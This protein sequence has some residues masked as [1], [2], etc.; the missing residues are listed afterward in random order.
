MR[1]H[2]FITAISLCFSIFAEAQ[3]PQLTVDGKTNNGVLLEALKIEI[4]VCGTVAR[5]TWQMTFKNTTAIILEGTLNFPLKDGLSVSRYAIDI[6]GKMREAVPVDRSKGT[7]VFEAIERRRVDP[8]LLEKVDGNTFRTRIYPINPN[9]KRTVL[10]GYEEELPIAAN[11]AL[12]YNLP[13]HL[14]D[15]VKDFNLDVSVIQ[16]A[17]RPVFD[18]SLNENIEFSASNNLYVAAVHKNNYVPAYSLSFSIPKPLDAA[19][20]MMQ[21][22]ENKYYYLI[23]TRLQ[24][25]E[26][27]KKL[28]SAIGLL[29]DAS[30]SGGNRNI[31]KELELLDG[32]FKKLNTVEVN[33]VVFSNTVKSNSHF[34][35]QNGTWN[36]L[37]NFIEKI[38]YDGATNLGNINLKNIPGDEY[39]LVS[40]G[41]Q[42]L[43]YKQIQLSNKPVYCINSAAAADYSNLKFIALKTGGRVIDLQ[44]ST[45]ADALQKL[46][47]EP[48]RFLGIK[49]N[50][51]VK[52]NYP[53][54]PVAV[55]TDFSAAGITEEG[56]QEIVFQYGY[57]NKVTYEKIFSINT[58]TQLCENFDITKMFAQKKI[59]ELDIQYNQNKQEIERLGKQFGVITRNTS[60]I[61]L[62]TVN[63]YVHYG[64]EPPSELK[65]EYNRIMK[66]RRG[67]IITKNKDDLEKTL[68]MIVNL[69]KWYDQKPVKKEITKPEPVVTIVPA[70]SANIPMPA[71]QPVPAPTRPAGTQTTIP[72]G[73]SKVISGT[74]VDIDGNPVSFASVKIKGTSTG[75]S[76]DANG[77][78]S[79][80]VNSNASIIISGASFKEV[81]VPVGNQNIINSV[82][83]K[84]G[85]ELKEVV[86]TS[87]FGIRRSARSTASNVQYLNGDQI[88]TISQSNVNN[89]LAGKVTGVQI[90]SQP[91]VRFGAETT[92]RLRGE[93][94][95]GTGAGALYVVDGNIMPRRADINPDDVKDYSVLQGP[96]AAALFG[97]D[98]ANGAVIITTKN[99]KPDSA[100]KK[101]EDKVAEANITTKPAKPLFDL[102]TFDYIKEIKNTEK[103]AHYLKYLELRQFYSSRPVYFFNVATYLLKTG[104]KV[105]GLTVLSNLA[106]L[107]NGSYELYKMLGYKLKEAGDYEGELS[108]F[109]KV[110]E[111][112]PAD[113]QSY[114]DCALAYADQGNYQLALDLLY[115]GM[116]KSYSDEMDEMYEGIEEIFL[117]EINHIITLHKSK[118]NIKNIDKRIITPL[119]TD[120]RIVMNWN[121]NNTDIDLWVTDPNGEK[122]FFSKPETSIGGR[123]SED[124]TEG[125]GPEQFIIKKGIKGKYKV[126]IDYYGDTQI[127]LAGATT[128]MAEIYLHYG[129]DKEEKRII[130]L[131]MKKE[132]TGAVFIGEVEL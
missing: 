30:L 97:P 5:T 118:L 27:E 29:W 58:E 2:F 53:S 57:G 33:L 86:V 1:K 82:L 10:I 124:F 107:E 104:D 96:A 7:E 3:M 9:S 26:R 24:N 6:N 66:Q 25:N 130:T 20:V 67:D 21:Q 79:V 76:C 71:P 75:V 102:D 100:Y 85:G 131:Q 119:Q 93:N 16:S 36:E 42:T 74:V 78:Y 14:K 105:N 116:T 19:E 40:D 95:L 72:P 60:L 123:L 18:S 41:R 39:V 106:E 109:K 4:K 43:G 12:H 11:S 115:A 128:I 51:F 28:P 54:I 122:C 127:T 32:Y 91:G 34:R 45:V 52:E 111:L 50:D 94:G 61:V 65:D 13:L 62:E 87:A 68:D 31:N 113:P 98:G 126:E 120:I 77:H 117:T 37:K 15:T 73:N 23:N 22:F 17:T 49:P 55:N 38:Q 69:K 47:N 108:A 129:T 125:F 88:N 99:F 110:M 8:G 101:I 90:S 103:T 46:I 64:I 59:A 80:R 89:A 132:K 112:R 114:R 70:P 44:I 63:D 92:V 35:V 48:F 83:E 84:G 121:M 56:V 81:E